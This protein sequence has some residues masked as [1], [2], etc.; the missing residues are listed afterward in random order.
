MSN[1]NLP[2]SE[3]NVIKNHPVAVL[4]SIYKNMKSIILIFLVAII[5][6]PFYGMLAILAALVIFSGFG[7]FNWKRTFFYIEDR[8]LIYNSGVFSIKRKVIPLEKITTVDFTQSIISRIFKLYKV[9]LDTGSKDVAASELD[10]LLKVKDAEELKIAI[11]ADGLLET[12]RTEESEQE[13]EGHHK[14]NESESIVF[15]ADLRTLTLSSVTGNFL[16]IGL[17]V[18]W[19]FYTFLDDILGALKIN[20]D[21]LDNAGKYVETAAKG[22]AITIALTIVTILIPFFLITMVFSVIGTN[23]RYHGFRVNRSGKKIH[24]EYGLLSKK[25]YTLPVDGINAITLKQNFAR[26]LLNMSAILASSSG[27]GDEAKEEA[28]LFPLAGEALTAEILREIL[29][30]ALYLGALRR[31][32]KRVA[33]MFFIKPMAIFTIAVLLGSIYKVEIAFA[34]FLLPFIAL[35]NYLEYKNSGI[36]FD[37]NRVAM[38]YGAFSYKKVI[39]PFSKIQILS[40]KVS[41]FQKRKDVCTYKIEFYGGKM[42]ESASVRHIEEEYFKE[43]SERQI[44]I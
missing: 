38:A 17:G 8:N 11:F 44:G 16:L 40:K 43:L 13:A 35:T 5:K 24:I 3:I 41:I 27:Y 1:S 28:L 18:V 12:E 19:G 39:V 6:N 2:D 9:K 23:I 31:P 10:I 7:Y 22:N 36:G 25:K 15:T 30:D 33:S 32:P 29:P 34:L 26:R 20:M 14:K 42:G 21:F 4:A 37:E